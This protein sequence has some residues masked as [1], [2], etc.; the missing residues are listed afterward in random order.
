MAEG[1]ARATVP[2]VVFDTD[3]LIW[4]FRGNDK[5][6][7][8]LAQVLYPNRALSSLTFMELLQGCRNQEEARQ[9]RAFVSDNIPLVLHPDEAVSRRAIALVEQHSLSHGLRVVDALIAATALEAGYS[10]ATANLKHYR[11]I[12]RLPLIPFKP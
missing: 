10:L 5:A 1:P 12:T 2:K 8:F 7:R 9:V 4:Y 6:R 11:F 3:V